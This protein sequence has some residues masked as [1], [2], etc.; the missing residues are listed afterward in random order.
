MATR[1]GIY[2]KSTEPEERY[3]ML[4]Y[5]SA[6]CQ[7]IGFDWRYLYLNDAATRYIGRPGQEVLGRT[8]MEACP[9]IENTELFAELQR[10]MKGRT[11]RR[12]ESEFTFPGGAGGFFDISIQPVDEGVLAVSTDITELKKIEEQLRESLARYKEL[13]DSL[14]QIVFETDEQG[15][16]TF[17]NRNAFNLLGYSE[18]DITAGLS[19]FQVI[20]PGDHDTARERFRRLMNGESLPPVE[21]I[22]RRKDGDTFPILVRSSFITRENRPVGVRGI[23]SNIA[24]RKGLEVALEESETRY[25]GIFNNASD[26]I[27]IRDMEGKIIE[28]NQALSRLTGYRINELKKMNVSDMMTTDAFKACVEKQREQLEGKSTNQRY[29]LELIKKDGTKVIVES[30]TSL[31]VEHGRPIGVQAMV[32]DVTEQKRRSRNMQ[33]YIRQIT[34]AQED[35]RKRISRELHDEVAQSLAALCLEIDAVSSIKNRL[36]GEAITRLSKTRARIN[37]ILDS[38]R[39]FSHE[40]RPG[41]LDEVG[42]ILTLE[43]LTEELTVEGNTAAHLEVTGSDRRLPAEVELALFR[44]AQ[45]ALRNIR[46]HSEATQVKVEVQFTDSKVKLNVVDNG[47]GFDFSKAVGDYSGKGKLGLVGM[48]ERAKL[49]NGNLSVKSQHGKGTT[50]TAELPLQP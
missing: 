11:R 23:V 21:Y 5:V 3:Q 38:V 31:I 43:R 4:D 26:A 49:L 17:A 40:L 10:C 20:V 50:I 48:N 37:G 12:L 32:R 13:A 24:V 14:P 47:I 18:D 42:L 7:I 15:M 25:H 1:R 45:E 16:I 19:I 9:G 46:K 6:S 8:I 44:I 41:D 35:E 27:V 29:E 36:P 34:R 28:V 30:V 33:L 22:A 39:R 2:R